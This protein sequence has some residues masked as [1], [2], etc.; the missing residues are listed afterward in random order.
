MAHRGRSH[1]RISGLVVLGLGLGTGAHGWAAFHASPRLDGRW[2]L[3]AAESEAGGE[4]AFGRAFTA[5]QD[6]QVLTITC[7]VLPDGRLQTFTFRFDGTR[8]NVA[9]IYSRSSYSEIYTISGW[10]GERLSIRTM[11]RLPTRAPALAETK[12]L[13]LTSDGTLVVETTSSDGGE[14][15]GPVRN[16][17]TRGADFGDE[18]LARSLEWPARRHSSAMLTFDLRGDDCRRLT[19]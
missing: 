4:S 8:T 3:V 16:S 13:W 17:Y 9:H 11:W 15:R 6:E 18:R 14:P 10:E 5:T 1:A 19:P 7:P 2:T 12:E